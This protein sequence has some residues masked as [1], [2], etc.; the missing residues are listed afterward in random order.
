M[1]LDSSMLFTSSGRIVT[2]QAI[3]TLAIAMGWPLISGISVDVREVL[4][5][6]SVPMVHSSGRFLYILLVVGWGLILVVH[7]RVI[8]LILCKFRGRVVTELDGVGSLKAWL[9]PVLIVIAVAIDYLLAI[10]LLRF[11]L[12]LSLF[13]IRLFQ[14][15]FEH[16][17]LGFRQ[18]LTVTSLFN[19]SKS[20]IGC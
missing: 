13:S 5:L 17:W 6:A 20:L 15:A 11:Q 7:W 10:E 16:R 3:G 4:S 14:V 12:L 8:C 19:S 18:A 2:D 1:I 9:V